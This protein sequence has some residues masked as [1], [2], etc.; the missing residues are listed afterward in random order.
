[1]LA[2]PPGESGVSYF[3]DWNGFQSA[4]QAAEIRPLLL[5]GMK[6]DF[7]DDLENPG[8]GLKEERDAGQLIF[9]IEIFHREGSI[10]RLERRSTAAFQKD[11]QRRY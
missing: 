1:L 11:C 8:R 10:C 3:N 6:L 9:P 5:V 7:V 2:Q 4:L